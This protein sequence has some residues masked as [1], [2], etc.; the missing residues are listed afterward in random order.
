MIWPIAP[1]EDGGFVLDSLENWTSA[2]AELEAHINSDGANLAPW[3]P[4]QDLGP[5]PQELRERAVALSLAQ[6]QV[7][8][9]LDDSLAATAEEL[10]AAVAPARRNASAG[11]YLD[12][13]G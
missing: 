10:A 7:I 6:E 11:V 2:L 1:R 5:L 3:E 9:A 4:A 13:L 8:A 12:V